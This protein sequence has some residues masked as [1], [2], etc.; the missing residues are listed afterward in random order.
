MRQ[1][2][3]CH[4]PQQYL[5]IPLQVKPSI[6]MS[7]FQRVDNPYFSSTLSLRILKRKHPDLL[8]WSRPADS[9]LPKRLSLSDITVG[10]CCLDVD[11]PLSKPRSSRNPSSLAS[12][13]AARGG[14]TSSNP[15]RTSMLLNGKR[16][17]A[18]TA[19]GGPLLQQILSPP[20]P[21]LRNMGKRQSAS[22]PDPSCP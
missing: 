22:L 11:P 12:F 15:R 7:S 5:K 18:Q 13:T 2:L 17:W 9:S 8:D 19:C 14:N 21:N 10:D 6:C 3:L 1:V 4:V 16:K 20:A